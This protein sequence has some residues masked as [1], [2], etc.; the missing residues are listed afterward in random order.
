MAGR[1]ISVTH[2]ALGTT[3]VMKTCG[4]MGEVVGRAASVCVFHEC[5]PREVHDRYL[6]ELLDLLKLPGK[7][8]RDT[9]YDKVQIPDDAMELAGSM[10]PP[11]G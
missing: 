5:T 7:A 2:E 9:V 10:G 3:R 11:S 8:R 4:M 6:A 1:N